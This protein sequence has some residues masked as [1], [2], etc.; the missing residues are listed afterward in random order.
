MKKKRKHPVKELILPIGP[1]IA[2]V[3]LTRGM[4]ALIDMEDA[5]WIGQSNWYAKKCYRAGNYYAQRHTE[6]DGGKDLILTMHRAILRPRDGFMSD[7]VFGNTLDNR[8]SVLREAT[9]SQNAKN[10]KLF[11]TNTSGFKGVSW[12]KAHPPWIF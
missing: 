12:N 7:H 10:T 1:S 5:G 11:S 6:G 3:P 9:Q 2:Y 4:Y 8:R